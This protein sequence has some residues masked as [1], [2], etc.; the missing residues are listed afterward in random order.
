MY[1]RRISF[2]LGVLGLSSWIYILRGYGLCIFFLPLKPGTG[3]YA[4]TASLRHCSALA[5]GYHFPPSFLPHTLL[6]RAHPPAVSAISFHHH[7]IGVTG[8]RQETLEGDLRYVQVSEPV[9]LSVTSRHNVPHVSRSK[10]RAVIP[11]PAPA[12]ATPTVPSLC[13]I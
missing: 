8:F 9:A 4:A 3:H 11:P 6:L 2:W 7:Q 1:I 13:W 10:V 5:T 12:A